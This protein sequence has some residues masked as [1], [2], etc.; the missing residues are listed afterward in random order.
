[1]GSYM[2]WSIRTIIRE[3]ILNLAKVTVLVELSV[4]IHR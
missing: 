2:F 1:M 3:L 4:K